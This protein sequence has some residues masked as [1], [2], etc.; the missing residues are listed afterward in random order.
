MEFRTCLKCGHEWK[1]NPTSVR[2]QCSECKSTRSVLSEDIPA[3]LKFKLEFNELK[4]ELTEFKTVFNNFIQS[5]ESEHKQM[6]TFELQIT[7]DIENLLFWKE[8][9]KKRTD[10]PIPSKLKPFKNPEAG[11]Q[12]LRKILPPKQARNIHNYCP[13]EIDKL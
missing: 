11:L 4:A 7:H 6:I 10:P 5:H 1:S 2:P 12:P 9:L 8:V 13:T 3:H